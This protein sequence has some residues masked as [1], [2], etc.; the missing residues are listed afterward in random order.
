METNIEPWC[1]PVGPQQLLFLPDRLLVWEHHHLAGIPYEALRAS[2]STTRFIEDGWVPPDSQQV[3]TT[4]RFVN[5][6]GGPDRRFNNNRQ[7]PVMQYGTLELESATGLRIVLHTSSAAA[8]DGAARA[9]NELTRRARTAP[10]AADLPAPQRDPDTP[11]VAQPTAPPTVPMSPDPSTD[12][13]ISVATLLR[14]AAAA[15]RRVAPEEVEFA[16]RIVRQL[17]PVEHPGARRVIDDF[18]SLPCD[19]ASVAAAVERL[20]VEDDAFRAWAF[21]AV[22]A[23]CKA[24]GKTTP[25]EA[26]RLA[27]IRCGLQI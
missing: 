18:R 21:G 3:D 10:A 4:W 13:A 27:R 5:K 24:D 25:K 8:A 11:R 15:D 2:A 7:L 22:E 9:L 20:K 6:S 26:E 1:V 19:D 23:L 17:L 16:A 14:Y 12:R